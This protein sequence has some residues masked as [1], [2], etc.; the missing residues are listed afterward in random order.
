MAHGSRSSTGGGDGPN[1]TKKKLGGDGDDEEDMENERVLSPLILHYLLTYFKNDDTISACR[2][3]IDT[4]VFEGIYEMAIQVGLASA[5]HDEKPSIFNNPAF[6]ES[7]RS[8]FSEARVHLYVMK[9]VPLW[10]YSDPS[11]WLRYYMNADSNRDRADWGLPFGV[12]DVTKCY[13]KEVA[14][15]AHGMHRSFQV[16]PATPSKHKDVSYTLFRRGLE[17]VDI[18]PDVMEEVKDFYKT[19]GRETRQRLDLITNFPHMAMPQST[20]YR[21]A[22]AKRL[23][24]DAEECLHDANWM[25][26]HPLP[27]LTSEPPTQLPAAEELT[28]D[29]LL[30]GQSVKESQ[31]AMQQRISAMIRDKARHTIQR[32]KVALNGGDDTNPDGPNLRFE[33]KKR[34]GR[35]DMWDDAF[36]TDET[37]R[38][39]KIDPAD[40]IIDVTLLT[41][42]YS[43]RIYQQM[44]LP[45]D[46]FITQR[47]LDYRGKQGTQSSIMSNAVS[48][49]LNDP[50]HIRAR[51]DQRIYV[52]LFAHV[53]PASF[54][55]Y[56]LGKIEE[57][58][59]SHDDEMESLMNKVRAI[60]S[61][62]LSNKFDTNI[63]YK[64]SPDT[65]LQH[66]KLMLDEAEGKKKKKAM[67]KEKDADAMDVEEE[68]ED[69]TEIFKQVKKALKLV[70]RFKV[71]A[72]GL[73]YYMIGLQSHNP[74]T[75]ST[76]K[77]Q[78]NE[79]EEFV[80]A[81]EEEQAMLAAEKGIESLP[82]KKKEDDTAAKKKKK[83][84]K[85]DKEKKEKKKEKED[86]EEKAKDKEKE[87]KAKAT[88][89]KE[90]EEKPKPKKKDESDEPEKK[91]KKNKDE[92]KEGSEKKDK[93]EGGD[94]SKDKK[95][96]REDDDDEEDDD[97]KPKKK[98]QKKDDDKDDESE[99]T[100]NKKKKQKQKD[101][102]DDSDEIDDDDAET[103]KKKKKK[104]KTESEK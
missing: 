73:R 43:E 78:F 22:V 86:K 95:R 12:M 41:K 80:K 52:S 91:E 8:F 93:K 10:F 47:A 89:E 65:I 57:M 17:L 68:Q 88:K 23:M 59:T 51:I 31:V 83:K 13:I 20:Y 70:K 77:L 34:M 54:D 28:D 5:G 9:A 24:D 82:K 19:I 56:H 61:T 63:L 87:A 29:L 3:Y 90:E 18:D 48:D 72:Q 101:D 100:K 58:V 50:M 32:L 6:L 2:D 94:T 25:R 45:N 38:I 30:H 49:T 7:L 96:K 97:D 15:G 66:I 46:I 79:R 102:D 98:K 71:S 21:L 16:I 85:E 27:W 39:G 104:K 81:R 42:M 84:E 37:V 75:Q 74:T 55:R 76:A 64:E 103:K 44:G 35:M 99:E 92:K 4:Q 33:K 62:R 69:L 26:S 11:V 67:Q 53:G 14:I 60:L 36:V 40:V 1:K